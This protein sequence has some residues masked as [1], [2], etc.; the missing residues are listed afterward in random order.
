MVC[1]L[2]LFVERCG[3]RSK[4]GT[5]CRQN[6]HFVD[7]LAEIVRHQEQTVLRREQR[8]KVGFGEERDRPTEKTDDK[9]LLLT[10]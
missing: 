10:A 7:S 8:E 2:Y 4:N 3:L 5:R 9:P 6:E 1:R